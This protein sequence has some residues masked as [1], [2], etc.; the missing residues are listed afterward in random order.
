MSLRILTSNSTL[1]TLQALAAAFEQ[2]Q[3]MVVR[4]D[5][6]TGKQ[7]LARIKGGETGDII[8]LGAAVIAELAALGRII[9]HSQRPFALSRIGVAVRRGAPRPDISS[10][11]ALKQALLNARSIA[12][13]V[14][15]ASGMYVPQLLARLGIAEAVQAKIIT[16]PGGYIGPLVATGEAELCIQ[17]FSELRAVEGIAIVG[18]L[19]DEVQKTFTTAAALDAET[20]QTPAAEKLLA[21]F[22]TPECAALYIERGLEAAA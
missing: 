3:G 10:V 20:R 13:T 18:P 9:P 8:V 17:Q 14:Y 7:M 15:G 2:Q 4:V 1:T 11:A 21:F 6:D 5:H 19:P 22:A 16:R 12:H